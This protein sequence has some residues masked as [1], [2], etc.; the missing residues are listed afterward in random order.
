MW[1][2]TIKAGQ[3]K[4]KKCPKCGQSSLPDSL[5][6]C[7]KCKHD[8]FP[9]S[10][11]LPF[12]ANTTSPPQTANFVVGGVAIIAIIG[13][14]VL[15]TTGILFSLS[16]QRQQ[17]STSFAATQAFLD[18][19]SLAITNVRSV[20]CEYEMNQYCVEFTIKN[21]SSFYLITQTKDDTLDD[22]SGKH[23]YPNPFPLEPNESVSLR[24][25]SYKNEPIQQVCMEIAVPDDPY[26]VSIAN[27]GFWTFVREV[28]EPVR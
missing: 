18:S 17:Q 23:C 5:K 19:A 28:C 6:Y 7:Y 16:Q 9:Q 15:I 14:V 26:N 27:Y 11:P 13:C 2:E 22:E 21:Q 24:C 25:A 10:E 3:C 4:M 20:A 1:E 8:F 12:K